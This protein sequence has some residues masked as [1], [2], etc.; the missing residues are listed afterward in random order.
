MT[1]QI[2]RRMK[3]IVSLI[4]DC[5]SKIIDITEKKLHRHKKLT[6]KICLKISLGKTN[7]TSRDHSVQVNKTKVSLEK[8]KAYKRKRNS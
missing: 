4:A 3:Y 2:K 1:E 6:Q 5:L 8:F 7:K